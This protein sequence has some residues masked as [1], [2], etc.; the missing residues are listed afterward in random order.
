MTPAQLAAAHIG[1]DVGDH[2]D[3]LVVLVR[4]D[5][6]IDVGT[7]CDVG[8][9]KEFQAAFERVAEDF[10]DQFAAQAREQRERN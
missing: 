5:G 1:E 8:R 4:S 9:T 10:T 7:Y 3:V 2:Y 6:H